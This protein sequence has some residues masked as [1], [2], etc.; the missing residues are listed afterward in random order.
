MKSIEGCKIK[1]QIFTFVYKI[2]AKKEK[3]KKL[4]HDIL[5][6]GKTAIL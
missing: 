6:T 3:K 2:N 1:G 4:L 5:E